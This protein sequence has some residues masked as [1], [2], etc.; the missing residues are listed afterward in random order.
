MEFQNPV[1]EDVLEKQMRLA[2]REATDLAF[3]PESLRH[4]ATGDKPGP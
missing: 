1:P 2:V 4:L 3:V